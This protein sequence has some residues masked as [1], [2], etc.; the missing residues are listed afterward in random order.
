MQQNNCQHLKISRKIF[1]IITIT[2]IVAAVIAVNFFHFPV[3][4]HGIEIERFELG[5]SVVLLLVGKTR[6]RNLIIAV[7]ISTFVDQLQHGH[8]LI[9]IPFE[10]VFNSL[11]VLVFN[12]FHRFNRGEK[13]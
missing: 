2:F 11:I 3:Y 4:L 9:T 1:E 12:F 13:K 6:L 7:V 10:I 5:L 8:N